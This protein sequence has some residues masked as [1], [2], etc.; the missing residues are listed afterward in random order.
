MSTLYRKYRPQTW[1][2]IADQEHIKITLAAEVETGKIAHAYLFSGPRGVG[3]TSMARLV[4]MAL[5]CDAS[6]D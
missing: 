6:M 5:N 1:A 2:D 4:A 3:K